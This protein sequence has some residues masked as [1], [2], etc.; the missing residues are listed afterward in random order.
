MNCMTSCFP[1]SLQ[2]FIKYSVN[3]NTYKNKDYIEKLQSIK[4]ES[5]VLS[6]WETISNE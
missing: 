6:D 4:E 2:Y 3:T 5:N 1:Y